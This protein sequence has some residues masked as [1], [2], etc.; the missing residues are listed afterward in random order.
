MGCKKID[1]RTLIV[2]KSSLTQALAK[3]AS[4][5]T[6]ADGAQSCEKQQDRQA[7][8]GPQFLFRS[9]IIYIVAKLILFRISVLFLKLS[10]TLVENKIK[11][12]ILI[13]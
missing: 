13:T 1:P 12:K 10:S 6:K 9:L 5:N 2:A 8:V 3:M 7:A 11:L 4:Y